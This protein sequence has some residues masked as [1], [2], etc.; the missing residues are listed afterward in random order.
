[1][2][3][4]KTSTTKT[5]IST[6]TSETWASLEASFRE[7]L[8]LNRKGLKKLKAEG[9]PDFLIDGSENLIKM[10]KNLIKM[11]KNL[12]REI[13][14]VK[15]KLKPSA[16]DGNM[17]AI[18]VDGV[19]VELHSW[20][21]KSSKKKK[22]AH[23]KREFASRLAKIAKFLDCV[24][25]EYIDGRTEEYVFH[26]EDGDMLR[27]RTGCTVLPPTSWIDFKIDKPEKRDEPPAEPQD[28]PVEAKAEKKAKQK[29]KV[30]GN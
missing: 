4:T 9:A 26:R 2:R 15:K 13:E 25:V 19:S 17:D 6:K 7:K 21:G 1:M 14:K 27:L 8:A 16:K 3:T 23:V 5:R 22:L 11:Y 30:H 24:R 12:L 10:Y 20:T 28:Q 29:E 18:N